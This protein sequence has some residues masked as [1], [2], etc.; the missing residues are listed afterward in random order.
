VSDSILHIKILQN[1]V[2]LINS[3][4]SLVNAICAYQAQTWFV[5]N[6]HH[7]FADFPDLS[8]PD[9]PWLFQPAAPVL[10]LGTI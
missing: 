7:Y 5:E 6:I 9:T 2:F 10:V 3:R 1:L 4:S 8:S